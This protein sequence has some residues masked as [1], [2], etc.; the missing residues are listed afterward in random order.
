MIRNRI[1]DL[2]QSLSFSGQRWGCEAL[3][4]LGAKSNAIASGF[5]QCFIHHLRW[6][7]CKFTFENSHSRY[8]RLEMYLSESVTVVHTQSATGR[9]I[10]DFPGPSPSL[11]FRLS[12]IQPRHTS[13]VDHIA[14]IAIELR[15]DDELHAVK[16]C[17]ESTDAVHQRLNQE[18]YAVSCVKT[19]GIEDVEMLLV[20]IRFPE[21]PKQSLR[22]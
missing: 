22:N 4:S 12:P 11:S 8:P 20:A 10:Q 18:R 1:H 13:Y 2:G 15:D 3:S 19:L 5:A 14:C 21:K 17:V 9:S 6:N 7:A 16:H